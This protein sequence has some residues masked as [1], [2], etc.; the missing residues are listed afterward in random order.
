[1]SPP[2]QSIAL[3]PDEEKM[4]I[5]FIEAGHANSNFVTQREMLNFVEVEFEK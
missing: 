2:H 3:K 4:V 5:R 1:M